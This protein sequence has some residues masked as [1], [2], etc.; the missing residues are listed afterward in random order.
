MGAH[1][2]ARAVL[3]KAVVHTVLIYECD[4]WVV[5]DAMMTVVEVFHHRVAWRL[6][7]LTVIRGDDGEW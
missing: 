7:G 4:S 6:L 2:K 1:V 5:T 3:Y